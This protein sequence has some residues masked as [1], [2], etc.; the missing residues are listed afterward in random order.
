[1]GYCNSCAQLHKEIIAREEA[2]EHPLALMS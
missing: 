2:G 1:L